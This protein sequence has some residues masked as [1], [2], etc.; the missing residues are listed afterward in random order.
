MKRIFALLITLIL[1]IILLLVCI[2]KGEQEEIIEYVEENKKEIFEEY[3][4]EAERIMN[5]M[6][7]EEKIS[8]IFISRC[9]EKDANGIIKEYMPG[10]YILFAKDF[11]S[12]TKQEVI[13]MI[14]SFQ[15]NSKIPMIIAVDEE[16][17][18]VCRVSLNNNLRENK[19]KS[20]QE[21][22]DE[23]GYERIYEDTIEKSELL[24][25]LG[26]NMNLAPIADVVTNKD[27]YMYKRSFGK[28]E[29][30]TSKYVETVVKAMK[31][32]N[33]IC[34]LKHFPGYGN[35]KDSHKQLIYDNRSLEIFENTDFIPFESG[36]SSGAESILVSHNIVEAI[37]ADYP[38][39]LSKKT[40]DLLRNKLRF[41][42]L[43]VTDDLAMNGAK[44]FAS[45]E[46]LAVMA[47]EAGNDLIITSDFIEQRETILEAVKSNRIQEERINQSVKRII[48]CKCYM[49]LSEEF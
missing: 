4:T 18:T 31:T 17:G 14:S 32:K 25:S 8:Q 12:K 34:S 27:D 46:E 9:P 49:K 7:I 28:N 21:L 15:Y 26:I 24:L 35:N 37:D 44:E 33:I 29:I 10:G 22:Y 39:S 45:I 40:H 19:F 36:I 38:A 42:G 20:P 6:T 48:A 3:Y 1:F 13:D 11:E 43:I 47:V 41:T 2:P 30:E 23:G 5:Q 16:G